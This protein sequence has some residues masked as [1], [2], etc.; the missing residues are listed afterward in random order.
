MQVLNQIRNSL[1]SII[2][3]LRFNTTFRSKTYVLQRVKSSQRITSHLEN[4][5]LFKFSFLF[6]IKEERGFC[7]LF[8]RI[9]NKYIY[10][11]FIPQQRYV[12]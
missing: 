8:I 6:K 9:H 7:Q 1:Y 3:Q 5:T 2:A 4:E 11:Y 12:D 10:M